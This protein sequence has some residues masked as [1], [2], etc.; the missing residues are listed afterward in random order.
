MC[1]RNFLLWC[2][3]EVYS[4]FYKGNQR[5]IKDIKYVEIFWCYFNILMFNL[6]LKGVG[7]V[8]SIV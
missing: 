8:E 2:V 3:K 4:F 6:V 1:K 7:N 5:F